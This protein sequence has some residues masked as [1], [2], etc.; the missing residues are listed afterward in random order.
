MNLRKSSKIL[1]VVLVVLGLVFAVVYFFSGASGEP[2]LM[3][4]F[5][6]GMSD[7]NNPPQS[8]AFFAVTNI[9]NAPAINSVGGG[10]EVFGQA[11]PRGVACRS[12]H[13]RLLPGQGDIIQV[14]LPSNF[15]GRWRFTAWYAHEGAR[16][17]IYD[18]QW[19]P[20]G[21]GPGINWLVPRG[22]KGLPMDVVATSEWIGDA[23]PTN[24]APQPPAIAPS[25]SNK[26]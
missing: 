20:H 15:Q 23:Q 24:A 22:L 5:L 26:P 7:T 25:V 11:R 19:G 3:V 1:L 10:M 2:R 8:F 14:F 9:G 13:H 21:L 12:S 16:S 18:L 6:S 4:T 17:R